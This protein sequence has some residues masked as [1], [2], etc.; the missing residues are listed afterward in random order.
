[1]SRLNEL[2]A[3]FRKLANGELQHAMLSA[4]SDVYRVPPLR[5]VSLA[6]SGRDGIV[7]SGSGNGGLVCDWTESHEG[8]LEAAEKMT[9]V[10][11]SES[12]ISIF[13]A[14]AIAT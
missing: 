5:E 4:L 9:A 6:V 1:V 2:E 10:A 3:A 14:Q 11:E 8:W 12:A 13:K 7:A